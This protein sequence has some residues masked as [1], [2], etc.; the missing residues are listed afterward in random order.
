MTN[1]HNQLLFV[2]MALAKPLAVYLLL[3]HVD[4]LAMQM[5]LAR[6]SRGAADSKVL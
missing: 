3:C 1:R 5:V 2:D 6:V 4:A